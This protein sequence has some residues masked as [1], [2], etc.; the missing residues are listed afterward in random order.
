VLSGTGV[1]GGAVSAAGA[2]SDVQ[3]YQETYSNGKPR[4]T[5]SAGIAGGRY[6]LQGRQ[7]FYYESGHKQWESTYQAG[8]KA[9]V[10]MWWSDAGARQWERTYAADGTWDWKLFDA[11]GRVTAESHWKGKD[12]LDANVE[13]GLP[14]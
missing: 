2:P 6:L 3:S 13:G 1:S 8:K 7:V 14:R 5:W 10:E 12:L 9:G 4:V 11:A